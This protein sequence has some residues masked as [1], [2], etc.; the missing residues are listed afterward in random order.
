[1]NTFLKWI[2]FIVIIAIVAV[3]IYRT[4]YFFTFVVK[5]TWRVADDKFAAINAKYEAK[6]RTLNE[7]KN[8]EV[9][10]A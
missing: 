2:L 1:M 3:V 8:K 9:K 10:K 5:K 6:L 7:Q 4:R